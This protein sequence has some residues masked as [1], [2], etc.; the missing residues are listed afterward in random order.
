M[1]DGYWFPSVRL[2]PSP[3]AFA[4][5]LHM[6]PTFDGVTHDE[7][8]ARAREMVPQ[9][10]ERAGQAEAARSL[11]PET[12]R[13]LHASGVMRALQPK[14]WGGME[15]EFITYFDV[16]ME[17]AR[18]CAST[19]WNVSQILMH[20]YLLAMYDERTQE[21]VWTQDPEAMIA[22]GIAFPQGQGRKVDGGFVIG[23]RWNFSSCVNM[24][25]WNMVA[26]TVR[27]G[28]RIV[29]HRLCL[30]H[31]S[32]YEVVD[33]WQVL[34][35]RATRSMTVAAKDVFVPEHK[36]LCAYEIRGGDRFPGARANPHPVFRVPVL[37]LGGH[38][39]VACAIG[40]AQ[41][42]LDQTIASVKQRSTNYTG[43]KMRDFQTV[44][45]RVGEAGARVD[46]ASVIM[47]NDCIE[48]QDT[49]NR[50]LVPDTQTKLRYKRNAAF[51]AR[52]CTEAV[53]ILHTMAGANGIYQSFPLERIFRDAHAL[54]GHVTCHFDTHVSAWGLAALGGE[55]SNP[56]L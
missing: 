16:V 20:H 37:T 12:M 32:Q 19:A 36:T 26:V 38:G 52:L 2:T 42:A 35:M 44:Q 22:T 6:S 9:L 45:L 43:M 41:A 29:D 27:D 49:A 3:Y 8:V 50:N 7:A 47:R 40:N 5:R 18:G 1:G 10:R 31:K 4:F 21:E 33:D 11:P 51:A 39:V 13:E 48:G 24:S 53:D 28:E 34:G 14:R 25:D 55:V 46:A 15:L 30:L 17:L 56:T 54:T 23:G